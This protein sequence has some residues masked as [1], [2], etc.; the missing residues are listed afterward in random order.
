MRKRKIKSGI[1]G[2]SETKGFKEWIFWKFYDYLQSYWVIITEKTPVNPFSE[3]GKGIRNN[4]KQATLLWCGGLMILFVY[5][6]KG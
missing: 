6:S 3:F 1:Y 4:W 2:G 5:V